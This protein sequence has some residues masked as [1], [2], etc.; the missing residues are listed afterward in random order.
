M[1]ST[2]LEETFKITKSVHEFHVS[3]INAL[4]TIKPI[5]LVTYE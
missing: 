2:D 4:F 5:T 3:I 1:T